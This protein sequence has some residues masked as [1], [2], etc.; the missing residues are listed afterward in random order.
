[1]PAGLK[2]SY[3]ND[4]TQQG[5]D[6]DF[7]NMGLLNAIAFMSNS[8]H[9]SAAQEFLPASNHVCTMIFYMFTYIG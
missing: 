5:E 6:I 9:F 7:Q 1:V 8:I 2:Y 3:T 4:L